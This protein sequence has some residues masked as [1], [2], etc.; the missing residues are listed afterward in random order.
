MQLVR[1][2][3]NYR[4]DSKG[5]VLT[6]GNFDGLHLGHQEILKQ[7]LK[8]SHDK[9]LLSAVM[10]FEP[11]P[12][13]FFNRN[14][15][16]ARLSRF[17][18]KFLGFEKFGIDLLFCLNFNKSLANMS[19][20]DFI[21]KILVEKL[22]VKQVIVGDDFHFG[23]SGIGNF[24]MLCE[25]GKK[26]NFNAISLDSFIHN[27]CRISSTKI[28]KLLRCDELDHVANLIGE[29]FFIRGKVSHGQELGRKI[30]FPTAN[31]NLK[32]RVAPVNG[33]YAVTVLLPNGSVK[34]GMANVGTRPTVNG[35][36]PKLE[37][38]IINFNGELYRQEIKVSFIKKIRAEKKFSSLVQLK[39]QLQLDEAYARKLF[40]QLENKCG[41]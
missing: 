28:R 37:V 41:I 7:L 29:P 32:R 17:R 5:I 21:V 27:S 25:Y 1:K 26:Y 35:V 36:E 40:M 39:E 13:E 20:N 22:N 9:N 33:V 4:A 34:N 11:Q 23:A 10:C 8:V 6:I 31:I 30:D 24:N 16:P 18:D 14:E 3:D 19:P 2:L 15:T 12:L 38:Y